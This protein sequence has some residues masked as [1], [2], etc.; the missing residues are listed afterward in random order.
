MEILIL[1]MV[2]LLNSL[3]TCLVLHNEYDSLL[4]QNSRGS[5]NGHRPAGGGL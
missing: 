2:V 5:G 4:H 3:I 1:K